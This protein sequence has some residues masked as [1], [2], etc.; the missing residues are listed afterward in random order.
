MT[1]SLKDIYGRKAFEQLLK[2]N[3]LVSDNILLELCEKFN[4]FMKNV[5]PEHIDKVILV[6]KHEGHYEWSLS[7]D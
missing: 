5:L 1:I 4:E 6:K 3:F 2:Y 7:V